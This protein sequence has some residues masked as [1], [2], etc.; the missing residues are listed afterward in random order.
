MLLTLA[1][2]VHQFCYETMQGIDLDLALAQGISPA[3]TLSGR[4]C[5]YIG[6]S[7]PL[8]AA[9]LRKASTEAIT[10]ALSKIEL[11]THFTVFI[12]GLFFKIQ[13][14]EE[15]QQSQTQTSNLNSDSNP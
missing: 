11:T 14:P 8:C 4:Q 7:T 3:T 12:G 6:I 9:D 15:E 10:I 5:D 1:Y 13:T 2:H